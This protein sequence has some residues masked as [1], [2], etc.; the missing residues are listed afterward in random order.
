MINEYRELCWACGWT[1][2]HQ[3]HASYSPRLKIYHVRQNIGL[4]DLGG[5]WVLRDEPNDASKGNDFITQQFLRA[6]PGLTAAGT[7]AIPLVSEMLAL[8]GPDDTVHFTLMRQARGERLDIAWRRLSPA[9]KAGYVSQVAAVIKALR[10]F[11]APTAQKVD[12]SLLDD[13]IIGFCWPACAPSCTKIGPTANAWIDALAPTLRG[14]L[15]FLHKTNDPAIIDAKLAELRANFPSGEP[16]YL[17][18]ADLNLS[19]IIVKDDKITAILDWEMA[20]YYPWWVER[21]KSFNYC[22]PADEF[23]EPL[24]ALLEPELS[25]EKM[26]RDVFLPVN[27]VINAWQRCNVGHPGINSRWLRPAFCKCEPWAGEVRWLD[28]G[29][30]LE[31]QIRK[32]QWGAK[33]PNFPYNTYY[34]LIADSRGQRVSLAPIV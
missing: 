5:Q 25:Y 26:Y 12:G 28:C 31:H 30:L 1:G 21:F 3:L 8:S 27:K 32:V 24:W 17:S 34:N 6:Q 15:S 19:N 33:N 16:Y 22:A 11:T 2:Y 18:H 23:F 9:Q 10:Q 4:W 20:G 29:N 13:L 7:G 14:G